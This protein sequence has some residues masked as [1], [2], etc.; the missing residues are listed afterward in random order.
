MVVRFVSTPLFLA[1]NLIDE[2]MI[3]VLLCPPDECQWNEPNPEEAIVKSRVGIH[4]YV[5]QSMRETLL[6][7][8][9]NGGE[10][11]IPIGN[12][13]N[14]TIS[15]LGIFAP[16]CFGHTSN[17]CFAGGPRIAAQESLT[18]NRTLAAWWEDDFDAVGH[19]GRIGTST[20]VISVNQVTQRTHVVAAQSTEKCERRE[21]PSY[22]WVQE[23]KN[24]TFTSEGFKYLIK[25]FPIIQI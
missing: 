9:I 6:G 17:L 1:Q 15:R 12:G 4:A 7:L 2:K 24:I 22:W 5:W 21:E 10:Q 11:E 16:S 18:F 19:I 23:E 25:V 20:W 14:V 8:S 13:S 3:R